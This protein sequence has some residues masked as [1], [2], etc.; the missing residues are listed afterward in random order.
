MFP[1]PIHLLIAYRN[2]LWALAAAQLSQQDR[3][4]IDFKDPDK[5]K[6]L[7][8]LQ[9]L[10]AEAKQRCIDRRWKYTRKSG[11]TV[12]LRDVFDKIV[13]WIDTFKR[14][15]DNVVQ[16]DPTHAALPWAGIRLV[17]QVCVARSSDV[18][19]ADTF[20]GCCQRFR[21]VRKCGRGH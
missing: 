15:G 12:I 5:L 7:A 20:A 8:D 13:K 11:E 4:A 6:A 16:Y 21:Q 10:T 17:L 1:G 18:V 14:V 2:D 19:E 3:E 9:R